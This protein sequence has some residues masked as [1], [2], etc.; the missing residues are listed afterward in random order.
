[1]VQIVID[2]KELDN[3]E[4]FNNLG[5]MINAAICDH[6][7]KSR[8]ATVTA[9]FNNKED[10]LCH[11]TGLKF[12]EETNKMLHLEH[13]FVWCWNLNTSESRSEIRR[14]F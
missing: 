9:A 6:K 1:M 10:S 13:S 4:Y 8:M 3:V 2:K 14:N 7:I 5:S 12:K 11:Q